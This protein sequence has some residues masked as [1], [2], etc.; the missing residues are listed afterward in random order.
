[1]SSRSPSLGSLLRGPYR[2]LAT[3]TYGELAEAGF[4]EI[5]PAH[6]AVYRHLGAE[7]VRVTVL[8][9]RAGMTKQSMAYLVDYLMQHGHVRLEPETSD[10][11]AKRIYLTKRGEDAVQALLAASARMEAHL[12]AEMGLHRLALLRELLE[13]AEF[14][15]ESFHG[16]ESR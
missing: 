9:E 8:A 4:P 16:A 13:E 15:M 7:G 14:A 3:Y 2:K 6:G 1:M 10:R 11:R 12:A 5:R